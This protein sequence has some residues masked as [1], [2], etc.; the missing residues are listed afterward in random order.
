MS[1]KY[2]LAIDIGASSGRHILASCEDGKMI[3]E[4]I[5]RFDNKQIRKDGHDTWD[6]ENLWRGILDGMKECAR[7]GKIPETVGIDTWAVDYVLLDENDKRIG[8]AVAYRDRRTEGMREAVDAIISADELYSRA[9]IQYQS[10]NTIYQLSAQLRERPEELAAAK[11]FLMI[12]EYFNFLLCGV[13]QNEYTNA[14]STNL[15]NAKKKDWD[16]EI[17]ERL[18]LPRG[19]FGPLAMP[20]TKLGRL[21]PE[22]KEEVGFDTTVIL[23]A[24]HDTGSAF[25]AVPARDDRAVYISS[26]TWSLLGVE[27]E[28]PITTPASRAENFTNEGGAWYRFRYLKNIMG[29]WII[30]SVRRELNG[31]AYIAGKEVRTEKEKKFSFDDLVDA[32]RGAADFPSRID[33]NKEVFLSPDSMI[34]AVKAECAATGRKVPETVGE[35]MQCIYASLADSYR[36][37]IGGLEALTGKKYTSVNIVGGGC[38]DEYLNELTKRATGLDVYAGP[39]E[40][41]AIGNL[42]VQMIEGGEFK[43]LREARDSVKKSFNIKEIEL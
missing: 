31:V 39:T 3:L 36:S 8:D 26:G 16:Y 21:L 9:G 10:F 5:F 12:P 35:L 1:V 40:G 11:S 37:A 32:A 18:G 42:I 17:I 43:D 20:G 33:V 41:T 30:Q 4:E 29:L 24:T 13:K 15:V 7:Q 27:N 23:P 38:K 25:L 22:I 28:E 34:E 6:M 2:Y 14:T 19:I